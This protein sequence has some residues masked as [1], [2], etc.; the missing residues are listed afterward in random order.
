MGFGGGGSVTNSSSKEEG[1]QRSINTVDVPD[2]LMPFIQQSTGAASSALARLGGQV[3]Q[4]NIADLTP[5]QQDA[6]SRMRGL[7]GG[8][9]SGTAQ[10]V[11]MQAAQGMGT[12]F[13]D[14]ELVARLGEGFNLGDTINEAR[15]AVGFTD[16]PEARAALEATARGDFLFGGEGF[17]AAVDAAVRAA[18]PAI[19]STFG[20][21]AGGATSGLATTAIGQAAID[22]FAN[23]YGAERGRQVGAADALDRGARADRAQYLGFGDSA[24]NRARRGDEMLAN[25]SE[26]ERRRQMAAA[27]Q[28]PGMGM[29]D[30]NMLMDVGEYVQGQE[31]REI[32]RR[33]QDTLQYLSAAMGGMP[34]SSFLGNTTTGDYERTRH[35]MEATGNFQGGGGGK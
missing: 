25:L 7:V 18:T 34:I 19:M 26:S 5:E 30:A 22:A 1:K 11:F 17:D 12:D 27:G 31:Q 8:D 4:D 13:L 20:G 6:L 14:P 3:Q 9:F 21:T 33:M 29:L 32:D 35:S 28:L 2:W 15:D 10:D 16:N 23:Q 24:A